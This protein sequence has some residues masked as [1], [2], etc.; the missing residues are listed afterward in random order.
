MREFDPRISQR[1]DLA[2]EAAE[3]LREDSKITLLFLFPL[4]PLKTD[5]ALRYRRLRCMMKKAPK[6]PANRLENSNG[7]YRKD[8]AKRKR[9]FPECL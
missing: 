8:M 3:F 5:E 9:H 7:K 2:D 4:S 1:T 6:V